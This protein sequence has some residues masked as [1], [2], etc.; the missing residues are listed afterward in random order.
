M[1]FTLPMPPSVNGMYINVGGKGRAKAT[2]YKTWL[3]EAGWDLNR[4]K[5]RPVKGAPVEILIELDNR[6][7]GDA[8]N[9][10]KPVLDLLVAHKIIP[11]D[12]KKYVRAVT[13]KWVSGI[14]GCRVTIT[15]AV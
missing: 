8:D 15:E 14:D 9:R 5:V 6:R 10:C 11:G 3:I 7:R 12:S 2:A 13:A 1:T 4:Q